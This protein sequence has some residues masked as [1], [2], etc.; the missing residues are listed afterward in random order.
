M[1]FEIDCPAVAESGSWRRGS[2]RGQWNNWFAVRNGD[3]LALVDR[4]TQ[5]TA[6]CAPMGL[7]GTDRAPEVSSGSVVGRPGYAPALD[8]ETMAAA[9]PGHDFPM[10]GVVAGRLW[11]IQPIE[12]VRPDIQSQQA[13]SYAALLG[14]DDAGTVR[15]LT[16][17]PELDGLDDAADA[18]YQDVLSGAIQLTQSWSDARGAH[19]LRVVPVDYSTG[20]RGDPWVAKDLL[21]NWREPTYLVFSGGTAVYA[22]HRV[23][24][25]EGRHGLQMRSAQTGALIA[26]LGPWPEPRKVLS[27]PNMLIVSQPTPAGTSE[28][29]KAYDYADGT[30]RSLSTAFPVDLESCASNSWS[31][32]VCTGAV[33]E[34]D[35]ITALDVDTGKTDWTWW[36]GDADATTGVPRTVPSDIAAF[37][38]YIY[39]T[40]DRG[41]RYI[42]DMATGADLGLE[43]EIR[44]V[45][46]GLGEIEVSNSTVRWQQPGS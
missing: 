43:T 9:W 22:T 5:T 19:R 25:S 16:E 32:L 42:L 10:L 39:G 6:W 11:V 3:Y 37:G 28:V 26:S 38:D 34:R 40:N 29:L 31:K 24:T 1:T 46:N 12:V 2:T 7:G 17:V 21:W 27:L 45:E 20:I 33:D 15:W 8:A 41:D 13:R 44:S 35:G 14:M 30:E 36:T 4:A 18:Y 23:T